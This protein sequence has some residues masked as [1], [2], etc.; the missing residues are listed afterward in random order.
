MRT[1]EERKTHQDEAFS[2]VPNPSPVT[3]F[4][5]QKHLR[6]AG[7]GPLAQSGPRKSLKEEQLTE[8]RLKEKKKEARRSQFQLSF[9]SDS[10][11][12]PRSIL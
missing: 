10:S 12:I 3:M 6:T 5:L 7:R 8:F 1:K 9:D 11:G 2:T 4:S